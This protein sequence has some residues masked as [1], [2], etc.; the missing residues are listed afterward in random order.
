MVICANRIRLGMPVPKRYAVKIIKHSK[1]HRRE[2]EEEALLNEGRLL[3]SAQDGSANPCVVKFTCVLDGLPTRKW[4][5][6]LGTAYCP[7][8]RRLIGLVTE[9]QSRGNLRDLLYMYRQPSIHH[10]SKSAETQMG[11]WRCNWTANMEERLRVAASVAHGLWHLHVN[12]N[13]VIVHGDLKPENILLSDNGDL[14]LA[15]FGMAQVT[16]KLEDVHGTMS[17][18]SCN[19]G[20]PRGSWG[21]MAPE[22]F[23]YDGHEPVSPTRSTDIFS[24]GAI[25]YE[26][27]ANQP[28]WTSYVDRVLQLNKQVHLKGLPSETPNA[29]IEILTKCLSLDRS[30]R[31][32]INDVLITLQQQYEIY[33]KQQFDVF[34]SYAYGKNDQRKPLTDQ[35]FRL[36]TR[37]GY[38]VW[39]DDKEMK[40]D[41]K[42]SMSKGVSRSEVVVALFSPDFAV[43]AACLYELRCAHEIKKPVIV[44]MVEPGHWNSWSSKTNDG[45]HVPVINFGDQIIELASLKT[46]LFVDFSEAAAVD[47]TD[48][49]VSSKPN[50]VLTESPK[51]LPRLL[52]LLKEKLGEP[53]LMK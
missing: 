15:D 14:K 45:Y 48:P 40:L 16:G 37:A 10:C 26:I 17:L 41:L 1:S 46:Q 11:K 6:L 24:F 12:S 47:W 7:P 35:L 34:L 25:I 2:E 30:S 8:G 19:T 36:L 20:K 53:K 42:Q 21:Y 13:G 43:S 23:E 49:N 5:E 3:H 44:C 31:P 27:L 9:F 4:V 32:P 52:N 28:V 38:R 33:R 18:V 39:I 51:A 22:M 29:I 50:S